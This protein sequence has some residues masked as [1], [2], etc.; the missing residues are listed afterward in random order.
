MEEITVEPESMTT[1][2]DFT[3][4]LTWSTERPPVTMKVGEKFVVK[5][6]ENPST[7]F[8]WLL[9][10]E[11]LTYHGLTGVVRMSDSH[12]ESAKTE[13]GMV[14]VP[15]T[16]IIEITATSAGSGVLHLVLGRPWEAAESFRKGE[17][18]Q[19]VGD[20]KIDITVN[21]SPE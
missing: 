15:G 18:Y 2:I 20:I 8:T 9:L 4:P 1:T 13:P 16:R 12:F 14:G 7:G 3:D 19:P 21:A 11:E 10:D 5:A 6:Q 17:V